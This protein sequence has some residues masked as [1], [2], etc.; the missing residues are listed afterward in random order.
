MPSLDWFLILIVSQN[1]SSLNASGSTLQ[2]VIL[3]DTWLRSTRSK[4]I[5]VMAIGKITYRWLNI[6]YCAG[7]NPTIHDNCFTT[8]HAHTMCISSHECKK[9]LSAFFKLLRKLI[10]FNFLNAQYSKSRSSCVMVYIDGTS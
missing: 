4:S 5:L 10:F 8:I 1:H 3:P 6:H 7:H 2:S 9:V